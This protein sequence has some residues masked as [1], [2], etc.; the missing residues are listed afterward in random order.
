MKSCGIVG[1]QNLYIYKYIFQLL[2]YRTWNRKGNR[3]DG[4]IGK[5]RREEENEGMV[6][7]NNTVNWATKRTYLRTILCEYE[8]VYKDKKKTKKYKLWW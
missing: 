7:G 8:K 5:E 6:K 2:L 1:L 3:T 4:R